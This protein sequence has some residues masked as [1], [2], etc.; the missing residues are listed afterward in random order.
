MGW[1]LSARVTRTAYRW[2]ER[3]EETRWALAQQYTLK[4]DLALRA[5]W[6]GSGG[7][8]EFSVGLLV[9]F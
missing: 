6:Q 4:R 8:R 1:K 3:S 7:V 2:G 5:D 9:Y